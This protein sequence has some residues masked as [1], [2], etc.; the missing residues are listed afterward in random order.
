MKNVLQIPSDIGDHC[1]AAAQVLSQENARL[2]DLWDI[3]AD[4]DPD[5]QNGYYWMVKIDHLEI[6][7]LR[8][9]IGQ[10]AEFLDWIADH[11]E[12]GQPVD[13]EEAGD[14]RG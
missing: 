3:W 9:H 6:T 1:R 2:G 11:G 7:R 8:R 12:H 10:I 13:R 5:P 14:D 4:A